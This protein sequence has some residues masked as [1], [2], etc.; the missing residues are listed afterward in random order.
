[1]CKYVNRLYRVLAFRYKV[2]DFDRFNPALKD[3]RLAYNL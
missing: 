1:M 3:L 2:I